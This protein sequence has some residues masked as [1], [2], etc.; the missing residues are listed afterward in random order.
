MHRIQNQVHNIDTFYYSISRMFERASFYGLRTLVILYMTGEALKMENDEAYSIFGVFTVALILS[1]IIG[2]LF[3]DLLIGNKKAIVIGGH[4]QAV[5]AFC[6][7]I[8]TIYGIYIGLFL[9]VLGNGFYS[10]NII[11]SF[12]KLYLSKTKLLDSGFTIFYLAINLGSFLGVLLFGLIAEKYDYNLGFIIAGILMLISII[13]IIISKNKITNENFRKEPS[14]NIRFLNIIIALLVVG[15]FWGVYEI[16]NIRIF[17]LQIEFSD[18]LFL[19]VPKGIWQSING[20]LILPISIIAI[21]IWT[22]FYN[23]SF[24][25][26]IIGFVFGA[27]SIILLLLIPEIP[28]EQHTILFIVSLL[29]LN[30]SEIHIAPL[31]YSILTK[32]SNPKYLAILMSIAFLPTRLI[33]LFF[34]LFNDT[35]YENPSLGLTFGMVVMIVISILLFWFVSCGKKKNNIII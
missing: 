9:M 1:Q 28:S 5:G 13:P 21:I 20:I 12:G 30:I 10:P 27:I 15:V 23:S 18:N 33:S 8:P 14:I 16:T 2:A 29:F 3:G 17:E 24:F 26:L 34:G 25:K 35:F 31:T 11:S 19:N 6:F 4:I 22:Y 7:C 32:Y